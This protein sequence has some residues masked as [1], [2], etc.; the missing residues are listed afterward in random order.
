MYNDVSLD[1][2][3]PQRKKRGRKPK[4][5]YLQQQLE[6]DRLNVTAPADIE[7]NE[8]RSKQYVDGELDVAQLIGLHE[9]FATL[10]G[11]K[12]RK[13]KGY[14]EWLLQQRESEMANAPMQVK[15]TLDHSYVSAG[16]SS[17]FSDGLTPIV[18]KKR[19]R[20]PKAYYEALQ[21]Q[22]E[23][24]NE[25]AQGNDTSYENTEHETSGAIDYESGILAKRVPKP[26]MKQFE[27]NKKVAFLDQRPMVSASDMISARQIF[28]TIV[29]FHIFRMN[30]HQKAS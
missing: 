8:H 2:N 27:Q 9:H 17:A 22:Q 20:K 26:T 7:L 1:P 3:Q 15:N 11:K 6:A 16:N 14:R 12:G 23:L 28:E 5:F 30:R 18:Y 24:I 13:P 19:G 21:R 10:R 4:S 29:R 25:M